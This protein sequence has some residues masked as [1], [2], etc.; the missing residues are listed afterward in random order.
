[1]ERWDLA[2]RL[3]E[4]RDRLGFSQRDF[5][6][7]LGVA[8]Q[9]LSRYENGAREIGAE[10]LAQAVQLGMDVQYV[11]TGIRSPNVA[12]AERAAQPAVHVS[13]GSANVIT[14]NNGN[15]TMIATQRHVTTTKVEVKAGDEHISEDQAAKL[16]KLVD[17]VVAAEAKLKQSPK[18]KRAV[19]GALNA[20]CG[21]TRYRLIQGSD[22]EKAEKYLRQWIGRLNSMASAPVKDGDAWRKR[23]YAYIKINCKDDPE[24]LNRYLAKSFG[25]SSLTELDNDQLERTY[26]AVASRKKSR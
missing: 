12:E 11:L 9:T 14:N 16:T 7:K 20:H 22:F 25:A 10:F 6:S 19:W 8:P 18:S 23:H 24:W 4:E 26:R 21:V 15:V 17:D 2:P 3:A 1:M 5:A 13:G